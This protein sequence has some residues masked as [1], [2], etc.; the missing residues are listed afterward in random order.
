MFFSFPVVPDPRTQK[1]VESTN[2]CL[3]NYQVIKNKANSESAQSFLRLIKGDIAI[4]FKVLS[5][6][7]IDNE[8]PENRY[9]LAKGERSGGKDWEF[10]VSRSKL[11]YIGWIYSKVL[12]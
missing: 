5:L 7:W 10:G 3:G 6:H 2:R 9:V 11:G 1:Q 4:H 12:L 8:R